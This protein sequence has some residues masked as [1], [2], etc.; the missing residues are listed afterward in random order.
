MAARLL[1]PAVRLVESR[2][3]RRGEGRERREG[4]RGERGHG[5]VCVTETVEETENGLESSSARELVISQSG[6]KES[7]E[8]GEKEGR[9][10]LPSLSSDHF[11]NRHTPTRR[12]PAFLSCH[13]HLP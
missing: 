3:E 11:A 13:P 1:K 7:E 6:E 2:E 4:R 8:D 10:F 9:P 12:P 5:A